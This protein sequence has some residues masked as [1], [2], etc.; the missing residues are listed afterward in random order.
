MSD[1]DIIDLPKWVPEATPL[2][3]NVVDQIFAHRNEGRHI[4]AL[5]LVTEAIKEGSPQRLDPNFWRGLAF[6]HADSQGFNE[7]R[8]AYWEIVK[9]QPKH[10]LAHLELC[11]AAMACGHWDE[12]KLVN[13][14]AL[15]LMV[16]IDLTEPWKVQATMNAAALAYR[17]GKASNGERLY[18]QVADLA[19]GPVHEDL[20]F[21]VGMA[22]LTTHHDAK[23]WALHERRLDTV[24]LYKWSKDR[25]E[26]PELPRWTGVERGPVVFWQEQGAGDLIQMM[27]FIPWI[28]EV[29]QAPVIVRA[30]PPLWPLLRAMPGVGALL[31]RT[32]EAPSRAQWQLPIMSAPVAYGVDGWK[33]V[34]PPV[35]PAKY[36]WHMRSDLAFTE[37][38]GAPHPLPPIIGVCWSGAAGHPGDK[39]RSAS[40]VSLE[41]LREMLP[42]H[43]WQSL[44]MGNCPDWMTPLVVADY[45]QTATIMQTLDAVVTCDTSVV[46][47][48]AT[49]GV[50]TW[51]IPPSSPEWRWG[52]RG[53]SAWYPGIRVV[54]RS[55]VGAWGPAWKKVAGEVRAYL[56]G[57]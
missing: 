36:A 2:P 15:D 31:A 51:L 4:E 33:T 40:M 50:P 24:A 45:G 44:Q 52:L 11:Q 5:P 57:R 47:L 56:E 3:P 28:A 17:F 6:I 27:R 34:P 1:R 13:D 42:H 41:V 12:A 55:T 38:P 29:S 20:Q 54:R 10:P 32:D 53:Q 8:L 9:L 46:H 48:A 7:A 21:A 14:M 25:G 49:L 19:N 35:V 37:P 39:D 43:R 18:H 26:Q 23:A 22:R 16:G 30:D